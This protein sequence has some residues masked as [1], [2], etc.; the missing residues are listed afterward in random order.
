[1]MERT[2]TW[3]RGPFRIITLSLSINQQRKPQNNHSIPIAF[4]FRRNLFL[5]YRALAFVFY[6]K[7]ETRKKA[8]PWFFR[9][10]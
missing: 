10:G 1:M 6:S 8:P 3:C 5:K 7:Y 2:S 4:I 9:L